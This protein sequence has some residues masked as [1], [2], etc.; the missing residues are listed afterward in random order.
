MCVLSPVVCV[1]VVTYDIRPPPVVAA[2]LAVTP[3]Q[4]SVGGG[5]RMTL[6]GYQFDGDDL[7]NNIV[8]VGGIP[9]VVVSAT[10]STIVCDLV[11]DTSTLAGALQ[12]L[13]WSCTRVALVLP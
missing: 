6:Y 2:V 8:S 3:K 7:S 4:I 5:T 12:C 13:C 9:C 11:H 10:S 1:C